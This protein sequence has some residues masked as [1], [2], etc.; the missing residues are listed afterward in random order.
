MNHVLNCIVLYYWLLSRKGPFEPYTQ[1]VL[2]G[3]SW[4]LSA[5][6][7]FAVRSSIALAFSVAGSSAGNARFAFDGFDFDRCRQATPSSSTMPSCE[8]VISSYGPFRLFT[9]SSLVWLSRQSFSAQL[10]N[11]GESSSFKIPT[12]CHI[13]KESEGKREN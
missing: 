10:S 13:F 4:G 7:S 5:S 9:C 12:S 6:T 11:K 8:S 3:P 1:L 2:W